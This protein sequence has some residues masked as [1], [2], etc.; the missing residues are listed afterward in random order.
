MPNRKTTRKPPAR[1][2]LREVTYLPIHD[3]AGRNCGNMPEWQTEE[4]HSSDVT[5]ADQLA[6]PTAIP[7]RRLFQQGTIP[8][9]R[10]S[11]EAL[12]PNG[13]GD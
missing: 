9:R 11:R 12:F 3:M 8:A 2:D 13:G 1:N 6:A 10:C 5:E 4:T 7:P